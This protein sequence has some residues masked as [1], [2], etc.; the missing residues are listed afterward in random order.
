MTGDGTG[1]G[2][3]LGKFMPP[4]AGHQLLCDISAA[5]HRRLLPEPVRDWYTGRGVVAGVS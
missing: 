4:H 2:F 5:R 1:Y 3:V